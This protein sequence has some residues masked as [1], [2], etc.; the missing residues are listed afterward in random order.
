MAKFTSALFTTASGKIGGL[1][2]SSNWSGPFMR[3]INKPRNPKSISQYDVRSVLWSVAQMWKTIGDTNQIGW[4]ALAVAYG[5]FLKKG[6]YTS[7]TG[8]QM[9]MK[10]NQNLVN[11]GNGFNPVPPSI[12][13]NIVPAVSGLTGVASLVSGLFSL[14]ITVTPSWAT[15]YRLVVR[16]TGPISAGCNYPKDYK[17]I[18]SDVY[19]IGTTLILTSY[20]SYVFGSN[21]SVGDRIYLKAQYYT[22]TWGW[23][24]AP[25]VL[26][27]SVVS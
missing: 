14:S 7:Y 20:W 21:P 4:K 8:F 13:T 2:F 24:G 1:V 18:F 17:K 25:F 5:S 22:A 26:Q 23:F 3:R 6:V 16:A 12:A 10:I 9:Y 27:L 15:G 19:S 11:N